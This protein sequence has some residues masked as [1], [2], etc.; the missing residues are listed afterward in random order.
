MFELSGFIELLQTVPWYWVLIISFF[1]T[2]LENVFPPAPCDSILVFTGTLVGIGVV[3]FVPLM[4]FATAGSTLGFIVMFWLGRQFGIRVIRSNRIKFINEDNIKKPEKWL[5]KYGYYLISINR[6]LSG[7]RGV[8]SF[9]AGISK[10]KSTP[11]F[12]AAGVSALVWNIL[13]IYLGLALGENWQLANEYIQDYGKI[14]LPIAIVAV[15][16]Y[17]IFVIIKNNKKKKLVN[18]PHID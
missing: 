15:I 4:L 13:L 10:M 18:K 7:T 16:A 17:I 6:F 9:L 2:F 5:N 1:I 3:G 14:I 11:T 8:L 12:L